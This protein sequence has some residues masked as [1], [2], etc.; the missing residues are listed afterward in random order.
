MSRR[1]RGVSGKYNEQFFR[2]VGGPG[3]TAVG[4]FVVLL[5]VVGFYLAFAKHLP[6]TGPGYEVNATFQNAANIRTGSPV[7]IA[8]VNVG[9]VKSVEREGNNSKVTF[10]VG[11][12]GRP[13]HSDAFVKIRPRIFLEG[14]FFLD[15]DP[16][17]PSRAELPNDGS[18]P[19]SHTATA[20][21]LDEVLTALQSPQRQ[22]LRDLLEGF[23]TALSHLPTAA[24]DLTQDPDVQGLSGAQALNKAFDYGPAAGKNTAIV[25]QAFLGQAPHDLSN[26]LRA[27]SRLFGTLA[28]SDRQLQ[29]LLTNFNITTGA[30]A[31]ESSNL[32]DTVRLLAPTLITA[33]SSLLHLNQTLPFLRT[34]A[35]DL[36]PGIAELP[37]T[38]RAANPWLAQTKPLLGKA[39]LGGIA[40]LLRKGTPGL[41]GATGA[42]LKAFPSLT[43]TG[44][45]VSGVLVPTGNQV[46]TDQFSSG[47]PNYREAFYG[48]VDL[49]GESQNFDGNGPYVRF[50]SGGG[51]VKVQVKNPSGG[52]HGDLLTGFNVSPF[53]GTQPALGPKPAVNHKVACASQAVPA[54]NGPAGQVG[55][56]SPQTVSRKAGG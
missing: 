24:E 19:V 39:E 29:D 34:Y 16:G 13:I 36:R 14:N 5:I 46:I 9:E 6:F 1:S 26:L 49:A 41:A 4:L 20:V 52:F 51:P 23:G 17:S 42:G 54:L 56:A 45:C 43:Q 8:G 18:I 32:S 38:I 33:R 10:T 7:R 28:S 25:N 55:P 12:S 22:D 50:Q 11:N 53:L 47:E 2:S 3:P 44:N 30:L 40:R 48:F 31:D 21:Q 37:A 27:S 35:I 15:V